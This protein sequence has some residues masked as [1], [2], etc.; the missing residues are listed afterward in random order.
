[1]IESLDDLMQRDR[2]AVDAMLDAAR[3]DVQPMID[4]MQDEAQALLMQMRQNETECD[5]YK[6]AGDESGE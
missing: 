2:A 4:A 5:T 6:K 3:A 1:M